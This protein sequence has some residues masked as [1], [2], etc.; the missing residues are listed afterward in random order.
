[1]KN[2]F[3]DFEQRLS[4]ALQSDEMPSPEFTSRVMAQVRETP[5][6]KKSTSMPKVKIW[7]VAACAAVVL[8]AVPVFRLTTMRC[9]SAAPAA[10]AD[11]AAEECA[12]AEAPAEGG[13]V[14]G[15]S[16]A[17]TQSAQNDKME[18][19]SAANV[20]QTVV[21]VSDPGLVKA[22]GAWLEEMGYADD[23]GYVL[24]AEEAVEL[25]RAVPGLDLPVCTVQLILEGGQ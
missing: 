13:A 8:L 25:N 5:Q 22:A 6:E 24:S 2:E 7:Q 14:Y 19:N 20:Q 3:D 21:T 4:D 9:G 11:C 15:F 17:E 1:M 16:A 12:P 10:A 18:V 23:G